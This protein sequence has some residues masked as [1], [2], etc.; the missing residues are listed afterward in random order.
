MCIVILD[1]IRYIA[2]MIFDTV[3]LNP[4]TDRVTAWLLATQARMP[5]TVPHPAGA[6][7]DPRLRWKRSLRA[8]MV[9]RSMRQLL[10]RNTSAS[11]AGSPA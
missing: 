6:A 4:S 1:R 10:T 9:F 7:R 8:P 5:L 2:T 11:R 3:H